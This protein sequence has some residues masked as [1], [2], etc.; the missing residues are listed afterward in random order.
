MGVT[1]P[2]RCNRRHNATRGLEDAF[3]GSEY[4]NTIHPIA[5]KDLNVYCITLQ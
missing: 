2:D 5:V 1:A 4:E 3:D